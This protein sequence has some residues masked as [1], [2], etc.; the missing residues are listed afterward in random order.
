[1]QNDLQCVMFDSR[2]QISI[3][4]FEEEETFSVHALKRKAANMKLN[5]ELKE[6]YFIQ[7]TSLMVTVLL[8]YSAKEKAIHTKRGGGYK[9]TRKCR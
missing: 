3:L 7:L 5:T 2:L 6:I 4:K 8:R 1:M 9:W